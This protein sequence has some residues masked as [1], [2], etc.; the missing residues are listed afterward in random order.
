MRVLVYR[1][2]G[3]GD[4]ATAGLCYVDGVFQCF[5]LEPPWAD[6]AVDASCI[7]P[8]VYPLRFRVSPRFGETFRVES[9]PG[10]S[11]ILFH[12]GNYPSNTEGCVLIGQEL[13]QVDRDVPPV[14]LRS[15]AAHVALMSRLR[16]SGDS[17]TV[18][19]RNAAL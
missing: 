3:M 6:N 10:R 2:P 15:K 9:V 7:P 13:R 8:G 11:Q 17:H 12:W 14:V 18:E 1:L 16:E 5:T 19:F 4:A